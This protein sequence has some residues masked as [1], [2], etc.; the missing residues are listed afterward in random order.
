MGKFTTILKNYKISFAS[1]KKMNQ[2]HYNFSWKNFRERGRGCSFLTIM[3]PDDLLRFTNE[4]ELWK[5]SYSTNKKLEISTSRSRYRDHLMKQTEEYSPD[6]E[7][8]LNISVI[9]ACNNPVDPLPR[10][11]SKCICTLF[12]VK[13]TAEGTEI[14]S[15]CS[16]K[17]Q[18]VDIKCRIGLNLS[19]KRHA[20]I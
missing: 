6:K 18:V 17:K 11:S 15:I 2:E 19:R 3:S 12:N 8:L 7:F 13:H 9:V 1:N 20:S 4:R 14:T 16:N 10:I 5:P